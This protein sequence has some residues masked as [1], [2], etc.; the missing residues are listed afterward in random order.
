[1]FANRGSKPAFA[2]SKMRFQGTVPAPVPDS[3][4]TVACA[5]SN[6]VPLM[7]SPTLAPSEV[8]V[9]ERAARDLFHGENKES[10]V[11]A[12]PGYQIL[13]ELGRGGMGVVYK[14]HQ[15]GLNRLVALKIILGGAHAAPEDMVRFL[16]EAEAVA[17]LQNTQIV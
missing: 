12:V 16:A 9:P 8:L 11:P 4:R 13:G 3:D 6:R 5:L 17:R 10:T 15:I 2:A 14:A 1:M 7:D